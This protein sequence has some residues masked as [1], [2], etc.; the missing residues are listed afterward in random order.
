MKMIGLMFGLV[1]LV[2]CSG[3]GPDGPE[4][5][6]Y[7]P[8]RPLKVMTYNIVQTFHNSGEDDP[9]NWNKGRR[10]RVVRLLET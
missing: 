7:T 2:A 3:K 4:P 10:E 6:E 9:H 5:P 1:V 8:G